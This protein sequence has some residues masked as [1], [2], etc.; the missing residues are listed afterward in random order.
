MA[1]MTNRIELLGIRSMRAKKV[2][3]QVVVSHFLWLLRRM[4]H[5]SA[6]LHLVPNNVYDVVFCLLQRCQ[7]MITALSYIYSN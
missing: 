6:A 4:K 7:A 3:V 5:S 1:M 2:K